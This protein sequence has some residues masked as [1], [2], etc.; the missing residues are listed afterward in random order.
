MCAQYWNLIATVTCPSCGETFEDNLQTHFMGDFSFDQ[1][2]RLNENV[3]LL[4]G[5]DVVLDGHPDSFIGAHWC[6]ASNGEMID[7]GARIE[8]GQVKEVWVLPT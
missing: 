7:F 8:K 4:K 2:Y 5:I 3:P 6:D 1:F